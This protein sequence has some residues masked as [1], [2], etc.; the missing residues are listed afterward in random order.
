MS[1]PQTPLTATEPGQAP[2][3]AAVQPPPQSAD[4]PAVRTFTQADVDKIVTDRLAREQTKSQ[5]E[6]EKARI[7]AEAA[8]LLQQG[9]FKTLA[10]QRATQ[11]AKLEPLAQQA[12]RY[13][14]ALQAQLEAARTGLPDHLTALLDRMDV[15]EQLEY[16][17]AHR[18]KLVPVAPVGPPPPPSAPNINGGAP[19][20]PAV[21]ATT[22]QEDDI[23]RRFR[24]GG[25]GKR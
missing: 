1:D 5:R 20:L 24:I 2:E 21:A 7:E 23:R 22:T 3:L 18:A 12:E 15:A 6:T 19:P 13:G 9:E 10:E 11:I 8:A 4:A 17:A 14:K 25:T 16:L